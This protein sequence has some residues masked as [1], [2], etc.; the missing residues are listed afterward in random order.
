[1][2]GEDSLSRW[3]RERRAASCPAKDNSGKEAEDKSEN[4][5]LGVAQGRVGRARASLH[6]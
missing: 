6:T 1:M 5:R 2:G 3:N 4:E